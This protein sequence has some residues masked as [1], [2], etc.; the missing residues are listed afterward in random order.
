MKLSEALAGVIANVT[1]NEALDL[2]VDAVCVVGANQKDGVF[3]TSL[4]PKPYVRT[5][6]KMVN[7]GLG[8][9]D[10]MTISQVRKPN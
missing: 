9:P 8:Q 1:G 6:L 2:E 4:G 5:L 7:D 10:E 3:T